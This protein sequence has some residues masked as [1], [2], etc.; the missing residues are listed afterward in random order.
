MGRIEGTDCSKQ[1]RQKRKELRQN[2]R[3]ISEKN[4]PPDSSWSDAT[5]QTEEEDI[6]GCDSSTSDEKFTPRSTPRPPTVT[7][8]IPTHSLEK[9]T[10][11]VADSRGI[12]VRDYYMIASSIVKKG[13]ENTNKMSLSTAPFSDRDRKKRKKF[14]KK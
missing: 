12:S 1:Q 5:V 7:L 11:L 9:S 3:Q 6:P 10:G 13:R 2:K 14:Q 8:E 4:I